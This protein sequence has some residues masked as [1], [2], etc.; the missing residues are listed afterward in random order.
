[1]SMSA[2]D[3]QVAALMQAGASQEVAQEFWNLRRLRQ[4]PITLNVV[5]RITEQAYA[6]KL[7]LDEA[8]IYAMMR[9][10]QTFMFKWWEKDGGATLGNSR[11]PLNSNDR[12]AAAR[13]M[14]GI[15]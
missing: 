13:A 8:L 5:K 3:D 9:G 12:D 11:T 10:W 6:A 7:T 4:A 1:M 14:L 15:N 2:K